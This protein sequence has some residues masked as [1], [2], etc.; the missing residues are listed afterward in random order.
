MERGIIPPTRGLVRPNPNIKWGEWQVRVSTEQVPFPSHLPVRRVSINSFGYGGTNAH[1]IVEGA[2]SLLTSLY[3]QGTEQQYVYVDNANTTEKSNKKRTAVRRTACR[4]RPF[5]LPFSAHDKATLTRNIEAHGRV[6]EQYD[7]LDLSHT[8]ANRRSRLQ[9]RAFAIASHLTLGSVFS[10]V[11]T[12]FAFGEH[13]KNK[14]M[15]VPVVGFIFTGQ[16]SQWPR[17]GAELIEYSPDFRRSIRAL[18]D[19]LDELC[20]GP[21]WSI[22]AILLE[23]EKTSLVDDPE[24]SQPLVTAV[25]IAL[26]QL[27]ACWGVRPA[28]TAGHSSGEIAAAYAAGLISAKEAIAVA[29][30]RG[31]VTRDV[32]TDGAMLAAGISADAVKPYLNDAKGKVVVA[33]HNSPAG[34][35]LSGDHDEVLAV[36]AKLDTDN[37][38]ARIVKTSGKAYHS[39]HMVPVAD[40]YERLIRAARTRLRLNGAEPIPIRDETDDTINCS[41]VSSVTNKVLPS[42]TNL[43]EAYWSNNLKNPVLFYQAV[44]TILTSQDFAHVNVL[45]EIGPHS[46]MSGP[47]KQIRTE[48]KAEK[49]DYLPSLLR[50][51]DSAVQLL[52][53]AGELFLRDYPV[54]MESVVGAYL[55]N[56]V[57]IDS[58]RDNMGAK[59]QRKLRTKHKGRTIVD[60]PPYQW[61][62][63]RPFWAEA[64]ASREHRQ[65]KHP[66]HDLLGQLVLGTSLQEPTWRNVL[67]LRD[68]PWLNDHSLGGE[69]VFPAAGYFSMAVE[70]ITQL[71]EVG[72]KSVAL[73]ESYILRDVSIKKALVTPDDDEGIEV[74]F[75]LRPSVHDQQEWW[76]F[77]VSSINTDGIQ[78]ERKA[79]SISISTGSSLQENNLSYR[80]PRDLPAFPQRATGKAWNQALREV[81]FDYGP[82][83]QDMDDICFDGKRY[84]ASCHTTIKQEVDK[85]LGES[86][87]VLHPASVDSVLQLSIAAIYAGRTNAMSCGV[88]PIQIEQVTM[89]PPSKT[90]LAAHT[91]VGYAWVPRRGIRSFEGSAQMT[92]ADGKMVL[93]IVNVRTTSYEAAVPQRLETILKD[94]DAADTVAGPY[95]EMVWAL[96]IDA[97]ATGSAQDQVLSV[98]ELVNLALFKTPSQRVLELGT[99][100][101]SYSPF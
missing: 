34:V 73:I 84:E 42:T 55:E 47:I 52:K 19:A 24:F 58:V 99:S 14:K 6:S 17:M 87:Y 75:N 2:E 57:V 81:G 100:C 82:T 50:G 90:Q 98:S 11:A 33:C 72:D 54:K 16:G 95:G 21:E 74:L 9:S 37:I 45:I 69:A 56:R 80:V 4:K 79:G 1:I 40:E 5:L 36:K 46:A 65:P 88:V 39:H 59:Y 96:D 38:F 12:S 92:A 25:Q 61:N 83:F 101:E 44:R 77:G 27:L 23:S 31:Q 71:H 3:G 53:L 51:N 28:V 18:D 7:L 91:A 70:A 97:L 85:S 68:L 94:A 49:F 41:M 76:D 43:D 8:L 86:R 20:D 78:T 29:Y 63:T 67:R 22:E 15:P 60:L 64:R 66:R 89:W 13:N 32:N 10:N 26:V 62:Y 30:Y 48:L 93:E 35:T